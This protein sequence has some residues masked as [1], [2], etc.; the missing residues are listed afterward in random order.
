VTERSVT[1]GDAFG[2]LL[3]AAHAA[4]TGRGPRPVL[5]SR[6]PVPVVEV[7]ERDD[8]FISAAPA[9]RYLAAPPEWPVADR[10]VLDLCRGRVLD[11]GAGGGR[12]ALALQERGIDVTALDI[13]PG[14]VEVCR[15]RGVRRTVIGTVDTHRGEYDTFVLWCN[16]LGLL[17]SPATAPDFLAALSRLAARDARIVAQGTDPYRT[18]DP[19]HLAYQ[20]RNRE[21][22][23]MPGHL[24]VRIRYRELAT[25]WF[26]YLLC[27][28]DE[29]RGLLRG[30]GWHLADLD[31][32][33]PARYTAVL[34][35]SPRR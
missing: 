27:S 17:G 26:D 12:I 18:A 2:E 5:G 8:G 16:N 15:T 21:R 22:G 23:R 3:R 32:S 25:P 7:V 19:V 34:S 35:R 28:P 6:D 14:A 31:D 4:R 20:R 13:S 24:T 9:E 30:T 33:E 29:L 11:V 10:A 1:T